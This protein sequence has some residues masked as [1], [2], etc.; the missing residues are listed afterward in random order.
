MKKL[1]ACCLLIA[2]PSLVLA[3]RWDRDPVEAPPT[4][5][6]DSV[7]GPSAVLVFGR[8]LLVPGWGQ[9]V[10]A[11]SRP[12]FEGYGKKAFYLDLALL[13]S[14]VSLRHYAGLKEDEFHTYAAQ[15]AGAAPH[16]SSSD[17][18]VDMSNYASR[19]DY[20]DAMMRLGRPYLRYDAGHD[21]WQWDNTAQRGHYRDLRAYASDASSRALALSG[22]VL[23]N[24][25]LSGVQALKLLNM[26]VDLAAVQSD[27]GLG[28]AMGF[29][30]QS[31]LSLRK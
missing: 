6:E 29:D 27:A 4:R 17:F 25:I 10:L 26:P 23:L 16:G 30:L 24:H 20:N 14:I 3:G 8:S 7:N 18:W 19:A 15:H 28:I 1:F 5:V 9:R 31:A 21:D 2:L 11:R 13:T 12:E 22:M